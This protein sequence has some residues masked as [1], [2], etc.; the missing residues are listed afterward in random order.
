L[1]A[2]FLFATLPAIKGSHWMPGPRLSMQSAIGEGSRWRHVMLATEAGLSI[3]LLC[4]AAL[5]AQNLWTLL[6]APTGFNPKDLL[7]MKLKLSSRPENSIDPKAGLTFQEY[8]DRISAIPGVSSA[9]ITNG[10]PLHPTRIGNAELLEVRNGNGRLKSI[11]AINH[12]ISRDYFRTLQIPL[13]AGRTFR[14]D[15]AGPHVAVAIVNEEFAHRFGLGAEIVG[16]H[17]DEPGKPITIVGMVGNVRARGLQIDYYP[18]VYLSSLQLSWANAYLIVRSAI[19]PTTLIRQVRTAVE[20]VN[21]DQA[22]FGASTMERFVSDSLA[23]PRFDTLLT[24]VFAFLSVVMAVAGVHSVVTYLI[25]QQTGE[26]ALRLALGAN[27][28]AILRNVLGKTAIWIA[29]GLAVGL[30]CSLAAENAIRALAGVA[31]KGNFWIYVSSVLIFLFATMIAAY[32]PLRKANS[33]DI[34]A[35]LRHD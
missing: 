6:S 18:E 24:G 28:P 13:L 7:V 26:I 16:K 31:V 11:M 34:V 12:S 15:D 4:G 32:V 17:I 8:V 10:P 27:W 14:A 30:G 3:L 35:A 2:A 33:I 20:S 5:I 25:S 29:A 1:I 23:Q 19:T 21:P 9:A 22:I